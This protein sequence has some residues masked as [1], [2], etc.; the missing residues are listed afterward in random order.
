M[1]IA[2]SN[3]TDGASY[4]DPTDP[5]QMDVDLNAL[6]SNFHE[7]QKI[8]GNDIK[9]MASIKGNG[10]G[11]GAAPVAAV[12]RNA[13]VYAVATG[14]IRDALA[15]REAG[16]DVPIHMFAGILPEA[17]EFLYANHLMP[18]IYNQQL[19]DRASDVARAPW[20]VFIKVDSGLGRL[21]VPL[22]EAERFI[23]DVARKP[24]LRIEGIFTHL[25]FAG[26]PALPWI[27]E[28]LHEFDDLIAHIGQKGIDVP[29]RQS[30]ASI[31][32]I[33]GLKT[34][35]NTVCVGHLLFGGLGRF[36]ANDALAKKFQPVHKA[37]RTRIIDLRRYAAEKTIGSSG[38]LKAKAGSVYGTVPIGLHEGYRPSVAGQTLSMLVDGVR[39]PV[40]S[41]SQEYS[42][43]DLSH[44]TRARIGDEV[45]AL[46]GH[47]DQHI[48][49]E[50]LGAWQGRSPL[51]IVMSMDQTMH[52]H[53]THAPA[54]EGSV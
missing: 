2:L 27:R 34:S 30:L 46:G 41:V 6:K 22:N 11:V 19:A 5:L 31:G 42:V 50:Q 23:L 15:I 3:R 40:V 14:G 38:K 43:L 8:V 44:H 54:N 26:D 49:I 52:K 48:T 12:L 32:V 47:G 33:K 20:K 13:G 18:T 7:A 45:F 53:Y 1:S 51:Q 4:I 24:K 17:L 35:T 39:A 16:N 9:I 21:G 37:V 28:R 25:P 10:Y 36:E 29:V